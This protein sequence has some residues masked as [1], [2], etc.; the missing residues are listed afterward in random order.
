[1]IW[2]LNPSIYWM[3][4]AFCCRWWGHFSLNVVWENLARCYASEGREKYFPEVA[5]L[6]PLLSL[7]P[8]TGALWISMSLFVF[9][10][11]VADSNSNWAVCGKSSGLVSMPVATGS[12]Q[13][14]Q[15][16]VMPLFAGHLPYP[17]IKVLKYLP[18][19]AGVFNQPDPGKLHLKAL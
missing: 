6:R 7:Q 3:T 8:L 11:S 12:S 19:T 1:M 13:K 4:L 18:H 15:I 17:R 2:Y 9:V 5:A 16:E 14:M 10:S